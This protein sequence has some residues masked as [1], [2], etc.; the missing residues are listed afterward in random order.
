MRAARPFHGT[1]SVHADS[2]WVNAG[3]GEIRHI[4]SSVW[5]FATYVL[6]RSRPLVVRAFVSFRA[7]LAR[8]GIVPVPPTILLVDDDL[9][10]REA[11]AE[12]LEDAGYKVVRA[13]DG[14]RALDEMTRGGLR[15]D[16]I[17]LDMM[18]PNLDG[19]GFRVAQKQ[20]PDIAAIPVVALTAYALTEDERSQ[21]DAAAILRK[22]VALEELMRAVEGV[23]RT[24]A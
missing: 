16:L 14:R 10:L 15:P 3:K 8:S 18:M 9:D 2:D 6:T 20:M 24:T 5:Q 19:W 12:A 13:D 11:A 17:L 1:H 23:A 4:H 22:P 7:I 21:L